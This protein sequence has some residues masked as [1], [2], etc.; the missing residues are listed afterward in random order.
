MKI[1]SSPLALEL[2]L[3][4]TQRRAGARLAELSAATEAPLSSVQRAVRLLL[5]D[6]VVQRR[7]DRRPA[8]L[9]AREHPARNALVDLALA[10]VPAARAMA[11]IARSDPAIE[12]AAVDREGYVVVTSGTADP[13]DV[14]AFED[15]LVRRKAVAGA[16]EVLRLE[17]QDAVATARREPALHARVGRAKILKG[18]LARSFP[19][20]RRLS[21]RR[22]ATRA[23]RRAFARLFP[24]L[25]Q[26]A[27]GLIARKH[28][29]QRM[30][31][32][33]SGARGD[34][35]P[36]SDVDVLVEPGASSRLSLAG[37]ARLES[38]L[39]EIFE[40]H[41]DV[42]TPGAL[43]DEVRE[44]VEREGVTIHGRG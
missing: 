15:I 38:D 44:A 19:R 23:P 31:L 5:S 35:G 17:H 4:L 26:R 13:R 11:I 16:T 6:A 42:M 20:S 43:R 24:R 14:L 18:T 37:L 33:G 29:L 30:R 27:L 10:S 9:L 34:L 2:I 22:P 25:S 32:F 28:G 8:Y 3:A 12:F 21:R 1:I 40:R 39:E 36:A 41:V 7:G